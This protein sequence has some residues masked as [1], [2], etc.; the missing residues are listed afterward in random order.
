[1]KFKVFVLD[2]GKIFL[3]VLFIISLIVL[4]Y[5]ICEYIYTKQENIVDSDIEM[6]RKMNNKINIKQAM[7]N[8]NNGITSDIVEVK[9]YTLM[10]QYIQNILV[11]GEL[12]I[13]SINLDTYILNDSS[14]KA[15]NI[16]VTKL[17]GPKINEVGNFC[18]T[19]HN[20]LKDNMFGRLKKVNI[21][22][23]II[24]TDTFGKQKEYRVYEK[25][26]IQPSDVSVLNQDTKGKAEV[27]L[28][29]CTTGATKRVVVKA[30]EI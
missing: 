3:I 8:L 9:E 30:R 1:M 11:V 2:K 20:Y 26:E 7:E 27:T 16:S 18:I 19:G 12:Q 23:Q 5:N 28:I 22:D 24:L 21:D 25:I 10:P 15:L 17:I 6:Q 4:I 13:P 29:T 14:N